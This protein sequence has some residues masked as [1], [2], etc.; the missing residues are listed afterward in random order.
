MG[1]SGQRKS[2]GQLDTN[3]P[4]WAGA[5]ERSA[6]VNGLDSSKQGGGFFGRHFR[7]LS[8]SLPTFQKGVE[9][10]YSEKEKLGRGR[11]LGV[12]KSLGSVLTR[13]GWR[14]RVPLAIVGTVVLAVVLFLAT[15]TCSALRT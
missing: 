7:S 4:T 14:M 15:R 10:D 5:Q 11:S 12:L 13:Q 1:K 8:T 3:G 9:K 6:K 2:Y